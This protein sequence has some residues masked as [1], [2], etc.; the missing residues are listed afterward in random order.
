MEVRCAWEHGHSG[1]W[2][3]HP[4]GSDGEGKQAGALGL[5][6]SPCEGRA[7]VREGT[8]PEAV[9]D[10]MGPFLALFLDTAVS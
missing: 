9:K 7:A 6:A 1:G 5:R 8:N 4:G 10:W 2:Q 3:C